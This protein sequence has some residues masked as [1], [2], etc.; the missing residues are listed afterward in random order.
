MNGSIIRLTLRLYFSSRFTE[1]TP[2]ERV[3]WGQGLH[4]FDLRRKGWKYVTVQ[5]TEIDQNLAVSQRIEIPV[6][7]VS[8]KMPRAGSACV[9]GQT[10]HRS[11][12]NERLVGTKIDNE[13]WVTAENRCGLRRLRFQ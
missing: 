11:D 7:N 12:R 6:P 13:Q 4:A 9:R 5:I 2:A 1:K 3:F 8:P 10:I